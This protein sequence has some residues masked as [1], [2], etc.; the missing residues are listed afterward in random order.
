[1]AARTGASRAG[2]LARRTWTLP[3]TA[4][5]AYP[6]EASPGQKV[7][8][9]RSGPSPRA[10]VGHSA[11]PVREQRPSPPETGPSMLELPS[12]EGLART[13]AMVARR[14]Q[15]AAIVSTRTDAPTPLTRRERRAAERRHGTPVASVAQAGR[16]PVADR[17]SCGRRRSSAWSPPSSS[18]GSSSSRGAPRQRPMPPVCE[19]PRH[20][21]RSP[22]PRA[23][24][25]ARP[26]RRSRSSSGRTS[27]AR[28][29]GSSP[30]SSS[31]RSSATT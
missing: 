17:R 10:E 6:S 11:R 13:P 4:W 8:I 12:S 28:R 16:V 9:R 24:R 23:G 7:S 15:G 21:P 1:M 19:L 3:V 25:S 20:R 29:A 2:R 18:A 27:S 14:H 26:M 22:S 31:R 30:R 5:D